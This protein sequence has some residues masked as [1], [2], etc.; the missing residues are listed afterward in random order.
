MILLLELIII[1]S[2]LVLG[3]TIATQ[4]DM[5]FH[6]VRVW[7]EIKKEQGHKWS[8]PLFLCHFCQPSSWALISFAFAFGIGI[9]EKLE[10]NLI[11][12]YVLTVCGSSLL[13][14]LIWGYHLKSNAEKEL[15]ESA[16]ETCEIISDYIEDLYISEGNLEYEHYKN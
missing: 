6:N 4:E 5:V 14:G 3:Y 9:I 12:Y 10:W 8:E 2:I 15:S 11:L 16:K 1:T 7:A 13:N